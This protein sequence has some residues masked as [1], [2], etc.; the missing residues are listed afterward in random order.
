MDPTAHQ[1]VQLNS[2]ADLQGFR[3]AARIMTWCDIAPEQISWSTQAGQGLFGNQAPAAYG[4]AG[5]PI[6]LPRHIAETISLVVC[7]SDPDKY[8]QLYRLVWRVMRKEHQLLAPGEAV[9]QRLAL[10]EADVKRDLKRM[11]DLVRFR[12]ADDAKGDERFVAWFEPEHFIVEAA[13]QVFV[14]R[15]GSMDWTILTPKGSLRWD[16]KELWAG[17]PA[18]DNAASGGGAIGGRWRVYREST[19][20]PARIELAAMYQRR[21]RPG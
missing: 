11:H 15:F 1:H 17:P 13:A 12:Q 19:F 20:N 21:G 2:G 7:H 9:I 6:T 8:D 3:Q 14:D 4:A 16:R 10:M 18:L 5:K